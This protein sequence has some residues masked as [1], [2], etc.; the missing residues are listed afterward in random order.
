MNRL[1]PAL[2]S[3]LLLL[4]S[5]GFADDTASTIEVARSMAETERKA[6]VAGN[7]SLTEEE[8][9]RFWPVYNEYREKMRKVGDMRVEVIRDLAAEFETLDDERAEQLLRETLDFQADRVKLR[10]SFIKKFNAAIPARKTVRFFQI[11]NKLDTI[12]DFKLASE[13]P[14]VN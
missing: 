8:A 13:I 6:I 14:L 11:D 3:A 9:E 2:F 7:M 1:L 5:P 10:K 12:I 4:A